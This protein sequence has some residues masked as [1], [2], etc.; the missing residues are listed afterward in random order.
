MRVQEEVE[1]PE[2]CD[3]RIHH[4]PCTMSPAL[5]APA[6][7]LVKASGHITEVMPA[8]LQQGL[9]R[10]IPQLSSLQPS[11]HSHVVQQQQQIPQQTLQD[12]HGVS[13]DQ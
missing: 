3:V 11:Q 5:Q 9:A 7:T 12:A 13:Q 8:K 1:V 2:V 6:C 4:S 10:M